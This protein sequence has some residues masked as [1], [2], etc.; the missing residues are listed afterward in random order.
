MG[1]RRPMNPRHWSGDILV[2][3]LPENALDPRS[4]A[5]PGNALP[6]RLRLDFW[7][8]RGPREPTKTAKMSTAP[9]TI[10]PAKRSRISLKTANR[11]KM[12]SHEPAAS[13]WHS[14][15]DGRTPCATLQSGRLCPKK[16]S[17]TLC[18]AVLPAAYR[19]G[20]V[21][22][23]FFG[24][25]HSGMMRPHTS[26]MTTIF[27]NRQTFSLA[28][29]PDLPGGLGATS[30]RTP[31]KSIFARTHFRRRAPRGDSCIPLSPREGPGVRG[32]ADCRRP[33]AR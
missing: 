8:A 16:V 7:Q 30:S 9:S 25:S 23:T 33:E 11:A 13:S 31:I 3:A 26:I 4:Q 15:R 28:T 14:R 29:F 5:Q 32:A 27:R 2:A 12:A 6:S 10:F 18:I 1:P 19:I 21:P 24:Q 22:D 17:G 20:R